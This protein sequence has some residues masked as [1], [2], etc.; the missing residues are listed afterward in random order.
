MHFLGLNGMPRRI[1]D[2]PDAFLS[3]NKVASFGSF[4]SA[5]ATVL[6]FFIVLEA[7]INGKK[8]MKNYME[9]NKIIYSFDF[10]N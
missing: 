3:W 5:T 8:R 1:P 4:I 6:F 10:K 9:T 2:Y 7:F